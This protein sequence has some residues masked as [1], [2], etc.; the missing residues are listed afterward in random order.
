MS[1]PK[2]DLLSLAIA[3]ANGSW[4]LAT[5]DEAPE[6]PSVLAF[7]DVC[8]LDLPNARRTGD[9]LLARVMSMSAEDNRLAFA[10]PRAFEV[11]N[12]ILCIQ[13]RYNEAQEHER[14][15][16]TDHDFPP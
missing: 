12:R 15:Q 11:G 8:G 4:V 1:A 13:G 5:A 14:E 7:D 2:I 10:G 6:Q 16:T 3:Q 9:G